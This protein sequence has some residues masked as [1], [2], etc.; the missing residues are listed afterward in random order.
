MR[1]V[2][3]A[4]KIESAQAVQMLAE[5]LVINRDKTVDGNDALSKE[6]NAWDIWGE[7]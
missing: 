4:I 7:D 6:D 3:P 1:Y 2:K 5:S